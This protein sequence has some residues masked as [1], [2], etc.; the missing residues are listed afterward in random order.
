LR[1]SVSSFYV[2]DAEGNVIMKALD[3]GVPKI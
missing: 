1:Q 3:D 2:A